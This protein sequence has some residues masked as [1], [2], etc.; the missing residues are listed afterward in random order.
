MWVQII[1]WGGLV[2]EYKLYGEVGLVCEYKLYGEVGLVCE[3]KLYGEVGL[4]FEY[5][6]GKLELTGWPGRQYYSEN[7]EIMTPIVSRLTN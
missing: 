4:V 3:Y 2:C 5:I 6:Y 7:Y 1:R